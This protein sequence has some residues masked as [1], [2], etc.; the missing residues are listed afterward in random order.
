MGF[1]FCKNIFVIFQGF[2]L[3]QP[4]FIVFTNSFC[5]YLP[6]V[7]AIKFAN[8]TTLYKKMTLHSIP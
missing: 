6:N 8:F 3:G 2:I 4:I 5:K 7:N 1:S